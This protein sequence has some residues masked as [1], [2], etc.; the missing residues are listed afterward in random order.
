[1]RVCVVHIMFKADYMRLFRPGLWAVSPCSISTAE[2]P[3]PIYPALHG[4]SEGSCT[5]SLYWRWPAAHRCRPR[6]W[7]T[8]MK[9]K[10]SHKAGLDT[11]LHP[12]D[13][14][15]NEQWY[16]FTEEPGCA[17]PVSMFMIISLLFAIF[18][19]D[20]KSVITFVI[21]YFLFIK[22]LLMRIFHKPQKH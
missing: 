20:S 14:G 4:G 21:L 15:E 16:E 19:T 3:R 5:G 18:Y 12:G 7:N 6:R 17:L 10:H 9:N 11:R 8:R 1:M 2:T 22:G 13:Q